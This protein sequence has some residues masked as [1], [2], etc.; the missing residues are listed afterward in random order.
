MCHWLLRAWAACSLCLQIGLYSNTES[1]GSAHIIVCKGLC[2]TPRWL[3]CFFLLHVCVH[4]HT[5]VHAQTDNLPEREGGWECA[6]LGGCVGGPY[7]SIPYN[8]YLSRN[9][10]CPGAR[11][12]C[13]KQ[14]LLSPKLTPLLQ[15]LIFLLGGRALAGEG[16][17]EDSAPS[18]Q[19]DLPQTPAST[20]CPQGLLFFLEPCACDNSDCVTEYQSAGCVTHKWMCLCVCMCVSEREG[21]E[22]CL[23]C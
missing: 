18:R 12:H 23:E 19:A 2:L 20:P 6:G 4:A 15:L 5:Q 17:P 22:L 21:L 11:P 3:E 13:F 14:L 16:S 1:K 10:S 8:H 7:P 9:S